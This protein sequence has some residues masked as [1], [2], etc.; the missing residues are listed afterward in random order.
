MVED[1]AQVCLEHR[2]LTHSE[3]TRPPRASV[4]G[5]GGPAHQQAAAERVA[6]RRAGAPPVG[7]WVARQR[8][9]LI[10]AAQRKV[11]AR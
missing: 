10:V 11:A 2:E 5:G 8:A 4:P 9:R 6:G 1:R 7:E 3:G